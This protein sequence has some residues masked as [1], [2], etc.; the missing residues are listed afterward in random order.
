VRIVLFTLEETRFTPHLLE[1]VLRRYGDQIVAAYVSK[2]LEV[3]A[4]IL[5]KRAWFFIRNLYPFSIRPGDLYRYITGPRPRFR[6]TVLAHL[7]GLGIPAEY[8][9]EI[10]SAGIRSR[11]AAHDADV[12]LFC[13]FDKI[14]GPRFLAIPRIGTFNTHLGKLPEHRGAFGAFW[15]LRFGDREAGAAFH[16]A[17]PEVDAGEIISEVRFPVSSTSMDRLMLDTIELAGPMVV[18]GL[19][20]LEAGSY[21]PIDTRGRPV[22][23]YLLPTREDFREFYRRG[24]RLI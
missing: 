8:I 15:V 1:P 6:G 13:P 19:A 3:Y 7:R 14:A 16:R 9:H 5:R 11:L 23:Y 21:K 20:K 12:F 10:K 17:T 22:G 2:P 18:E 4:R 24:C